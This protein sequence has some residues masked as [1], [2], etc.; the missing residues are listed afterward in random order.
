ME[1][2]SRTEGER[3]PFEAP[4]IARRRRAAATSYFKRLFASSGAGGVIDA[5]MGVRRHAVAVA[6]GWGSAFLERLVRPSPIAKIL[7]NI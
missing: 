1:R 5:R 6:V 4:T 2:A 7:Y 3:R